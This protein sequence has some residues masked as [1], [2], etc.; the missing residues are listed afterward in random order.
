M[1][2]TLVRLLRGENCTEHGHRLEQVERKAYAASYG[3]FRCVADSVVQVAIRCRR[4][5]VVQGEWETVRSSHLQGLS[6][7]TAH[8]DELDEKGFL[9]KGPIRRLRDA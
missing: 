6:M 4:C 5:R 9:L 8:M 7:E 1:L 3:H 2:S